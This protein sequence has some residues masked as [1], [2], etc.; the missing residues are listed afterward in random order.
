MSLVRRWVIH[1]SYVRG[2]HSHSATRSWA[3]SSPGR[4]EP[5]TLTQLS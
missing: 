4:D 3:T 5:F 2:H 1:Y